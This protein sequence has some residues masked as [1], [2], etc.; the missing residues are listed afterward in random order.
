M[1]RGETTL[2]TCRH[3][4]GHDGVH[5]ICECVNC[6]YAWPNTE[7]HGQPLAASRAEPTTTRGMSEVTDYANSGLRERARGF[8]DKCGYPVNTRAL[9]E[10]AKQVLGEAAE[11]AWQMQRAE[12]R[13][14]IGNAIR[15]LGE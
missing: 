11:I 10:F 2:G 15:K 3:E 1:S 7:W 9:A 8:A 5:A 14:E 6:D 4:C 12:G 13:S